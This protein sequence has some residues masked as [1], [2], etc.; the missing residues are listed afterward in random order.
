MLVKA[1]SSTV[2]GIDGIIITVEVDASTGCITTIVG[3]PDNAVK[4]SYQRIRAAFYNTGMLP[5]SRN[6][7]VNLAPAD[8][9]KEGSHYDLPI[10]VGILGASGSISSENISKYVILGE[11]SLDGTVAPVKGALP[12]AI[13]T[14]N[15]GF[16]G[17]IL[18]KEN[19]R[20]AAV[21]QGIKVYGVDNIAQV[22]KIL[23]GEADIAPTIVNT[24]DEYFLNYD[25]FDID[26]FDV[27][28]QGAAKRALEVA[29]AGGH[30]VIL[31]GAPGSGKSMLASRMPTIMPPMT[32]SEALEATKIHSVAGKVGTSGGLLPHRPFRS[33]HHTVSD[34]ALVGGGSTPK[35]GE[36]SLAHNGVLFMDEMPEFSRHAL[37]VMRQPLEEREI[38]ISRANYTVRYPANFMLLGAM[39][40]CPCGYRTHP[41]KQCTCGA[42]A[43]QRYVSKIS[44]PLLDRIDIH[45]EV[46][47]VDVASMAARRSGEKSA[48]IRARVIAAREVQIKRFEGTKVHCNAM[49]TPSMMEEHCAMDEA[50]SDMLRA[51]M[52]KFEL[53]ARAYDRI[54]RVARTIADLAGEQNIGADHI[55]EAIGY[56][57][58]DRANWITF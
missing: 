32:L 21:V 16:E 39:N 26:F 51:A 14:L 58:I 24:R 5:P 53:S 15:A 52:S 30:N 17:L 10:A 35:P 1:Y 20:E 44:G 42:A 47:P 9:R 38:E 55:A 6:I 28:G 13:A 25:K 4:E 56:R 31:V 12:I 11:M 7:V 8:I 36:I 18:P 57:S 41:T 50:T 48:D 29:A 23:E 54:V 27:K 33:P 34:V 19:A 40:P 46:F 43:V 49:M 37:E 45:I 22:V 3:L 2:S